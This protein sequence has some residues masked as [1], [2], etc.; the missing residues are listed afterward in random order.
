MTNK[1]LQ[2]LDRLFS[3]N[4]TGGLLNPGWQKKKK[5][6]PL[7]LISQCNQVFVNTVI[8]INLETYLEPGQ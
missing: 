8:I 7:R 6:N 3:Y 1:Y 5:K 2:C 4:G